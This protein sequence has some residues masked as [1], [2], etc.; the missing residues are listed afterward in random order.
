MNYI[1]GLAVKYAA[2]INPD[3]TPEEVASVGNKLRDRIFLQQYATEMRFKADH[4][5]RHIYACVTRCERILTGEESDVKLAAIIGIVYHDIGYLDEDILYGSLDEEG[6]R[7]YADES[8]HAMRSSAWFERNDMEFWNGLNL[9]SESTFNSIRKAIIQQDLSIE[10]EIRKRGVTELDET[11]SKRVLRTVSMN[12]DINREPIVAAV[13]LSDKLALSDNENMPW[14]YMM[15][16]RSLYYAMKAYSV[17]T[18]SECLDDELEGKVLDKFK[19]ELKPLYAAMPNLSNYMKAEAIDRDLTLSS[20]QEFAPMVVAYTDANCVRMSPAKV[21]KYIMINVK[22][23]NYDA[24]VKSFGEDVASAQFVKL[25][26]SLGL[27]RKQ[28]IDPDTLDEAFSTY[29]LKL[30]GSHIVVRIRKVSLP[31]DSKRKMEVYHMA[32]AT[33]DGLYPVSRDFRRTQLLYDRDDLGDPVTGLMNRVL[34]SIDGSAVPAS[35]QD[36]RRAYRKWINQDHEKRN[37]P[38][39][40]TDFKN[41][42]TNSRLPVHVNREWP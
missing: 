36:S 20:M 1:I 3:L 2:D 13:Q 9:F 10:S 42:V 28:A 40:L 8:D 30:M 38:Q 12:L 32:L 24:A 4:G 11:E 23:V 31:Q 7:V 41:C 17:G 18:F 25:F 35:E 22:A 16:A 19:A 29:G 34:R 27:T 15:D 21:S 5:V 37:Y 26:M 33:N 6:N 39:L 14:L